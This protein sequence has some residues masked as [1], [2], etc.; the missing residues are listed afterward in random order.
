MHFLGFCLAKGFQC[1][2]SVESDGRASQVARDNIMINRIHNATVINE[3]VE[4]YLT[5]AQ[6]RNDDV[7][8]VDPARSGLHPKLLKAL[9]ADGPA[10]LIYIS[11]NPTTQARDFASLKEK[12]RASQWQLFDMYPHTPH[13]ESVLVLE[14]GI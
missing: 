9:C 10:Q 11:C 14:K 6:F 1:V 4:K 13:I 2:I 7:L 5:V 12:Y 8:V 3:R